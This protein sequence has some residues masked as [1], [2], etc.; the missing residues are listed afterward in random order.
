MNLSDC[1]CNSKAGGRASARAAEGCF[2]LSQGRQKDGN[3]V[4]FWDI[5]SVI[6]EQIML[7]LLNMILEELQTIILDL[8]WD[9]EIM[10]LMKEIVFIKCPDNLFGVVL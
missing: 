7:L 9:M 5:L 3:D 2:M 6:M 8:L 10:L 1:K 4:L